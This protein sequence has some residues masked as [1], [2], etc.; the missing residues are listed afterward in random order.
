MAHLL[1]EDPILRPAYDVLFGIALPALVLT[2][3]LRMEHLGQ[4]VEMLPLRPWSS[5][6]AFG[7]MAV[8]AAWLPL[9]RHPGW[10]QAAAAGAFLGGAVF[11]GTM[12]VVLFP[13]ALIGTLFGIGI[14]G[15]VPLV[16]CHVF[17]RASRES[18]IAARTRMSIA[19]T[20][21]V[22]LLSAA[23]LGG[24]LFGSGW[25]VRSV[26]GHAADVV[27]GVTRGDAAAAEG[28]LGGLRWFP[29]VGLSDLRRL[30]TDGSRPKAV[31]EK[32]R[33]AFE[34]ISGHPFAGSD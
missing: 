19:A 16:T 6:G 7:C 17:W 30:G 26:E 2:L 4:T 10:W 1:R 32:A 25:L 22:V 9:R 8:L 15:F 28:T 23:L 14:L 29:G 24:A 21:A 18:W 34:R 13:F 33:A 27:A 11:A 20:L 12:G 5:M 3:D 31:Q